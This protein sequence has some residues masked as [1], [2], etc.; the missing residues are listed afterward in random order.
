MTTVAEYETN[1]NRLEKEFEN[2]F[3]YLN[4]DDD[5]HDDHDH[6]NDDHDDLFL[7]EI[8]ETREFV[9]WKTLPTGHGCMDDND[10]KNKKERDTDADFGTLEDL[11]KFYKER[12]KTVQGEV[13]RLA[14]ELEVKNNKEIML[15]AAVE[16]A[17]MNLKTERDVHNQT[18][19][20]LKENEELLENT[21]QTVSDGER[22]KEK[23]NKTLQSQ[24]R[25]IVDLLR[26]ITELKESNTEKENKIDMLLSE[27]Y[28]KGRNPR[29]IHRCCPPT[30]AKDLAS[31]G[32]YRR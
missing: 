6:N 1:L 3:P 24:E 11:K 10:K 21:L 17:E 18:R 23:M 2:L 32:V 14:Q 8:P 25:F 19:E 20:K 13:M 4:N 5:H 29:I 7:K 30:D 31:R 28:T 15:N 26:K 12:L 9:H 22:T 16:I 27:S